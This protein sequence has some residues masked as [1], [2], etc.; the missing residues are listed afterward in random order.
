MFAC[1]KC[2]FIKIISQDLQDIACDLIARQ[3][4]ENMATN[5]NSHNVDYEQYISLFKDAT[6]REVEHE[7]HLV[8]VL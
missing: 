8:H 7:E 3:T 2:S 1:A 6:E 4:T 5:N